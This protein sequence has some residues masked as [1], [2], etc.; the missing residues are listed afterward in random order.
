MQAAEETRREGSPRADGPLSGIRV[1]DLTHILA[2][3]FCTQLMADAGAQVI[4]I[5]PPG[6]E[7]SRIRGPLRRAPSGDFLSSYSAGVNRGKTSLQLD[8][9][10]PE[11]RNLL[12]KLVAVSDVI[13]DN[14]APGALGRLGISY[15]ELR[16]RYPRLITAS[17]TLWGVDASDELAR[18][19]GVAV[20]AEAESTITAGRLDVDGTP[21]LIGFPLGDM[22]TGL[23][24][25]GAIVTALFERARTGRSRHVNIAM[26]RTLL[27]LNTPNIALA[28]LPQPPPRTRVAFGFFKAADGWVALEAP[29][30]PAWSRLCE[31]MGAGQL[32]IDPRYRDLEQRNQRAE[33]VNSMISAWTFHL[34]TAEI[35]DRLVPLGIPVGRVARPEDVLDSETFDRLGYL[36]DLEDGVGGTIKAPSNPFDLAFSVKRIPAVGEGAAEL[37]KSILDLDDQDLGVLARS[38]GARRESQ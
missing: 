20:V 4:K 22:S 27:A 17:I 1:V 21:L 28:Q 26:I 12:E 38:A 24:C 32:A 9:K 8:L 23:A 7:Y 15:D 11:G 31:A 3:P 5:E 25:Y 16:E 13:I 29:A 2:G 14:F 30:D 34:S 18:R 19:G 37:L 35:V 36:W 6:G 10:R 33:E